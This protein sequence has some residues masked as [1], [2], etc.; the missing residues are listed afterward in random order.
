[1]DRLQTKMPWLLMVG[2]VGFMPALLMGGHYWEFMTSDGRSSYV[3]CRQ[4]NC[5]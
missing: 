5:M 1:M 4:G 2:L 3:D